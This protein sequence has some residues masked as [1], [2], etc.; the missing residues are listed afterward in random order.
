MKL[1]VATVLFIALTVLRL[2]FLMW[3]LLFGTMLPEALFLFLEYVLP[4]VGVCSVI[5]YLSQFSRYRT[6]HLEYDNIPH[7]VPLAQSKSSH[8]ALHLLLQLLPF[9]PLSILGDFR[10]RTCHKEHTTEFHSVKLL[11]PRVSTLHG[12]LCITTIHFL[13]S[14][15]S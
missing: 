3:S 13:T 15:S 4:E 7:E 6:F 1:V 12:L 14:T 10:V 5:L 2:F 11:S 8:N 9:S